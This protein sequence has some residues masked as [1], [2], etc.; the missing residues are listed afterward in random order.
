MGP[1]DEP[2][3]GTTSQAQRTALV[4]RTGQQRVSRELL[5]L[6]VTSAVS[7]STA[8]SIAPLAARK[9]DTDFLDV[10]QAFPPSVG[11]ALTYKRQQRIFLAGLP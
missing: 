2:V 3:V 8:A 7:M 11:R 1:A 9:A 5:D 4:G 6:A 10:R